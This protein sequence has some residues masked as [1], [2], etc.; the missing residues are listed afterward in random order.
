VS[1]R[2]GPRET[3]LRAAIELVRERGLRGRWTLSEVCQ[4]AG[5][6]RQTLYVHFRDREDLLAA[7]L[8]HVLDARAVALGAAT[9]QADLR[10]EI[11]KFLELFGPGPLDSEDWGMLEVLEVARSSERLKRE[12]REFIVD[13]RRR[14]TARVAMN[15]RD[16]VVDPALDPQAIGGILTAVIFSASLYLQLG[17]PMEPLR[18][19]SELQ[20]MLR[21]SLGPLDG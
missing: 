5:L 11:V 3:I 19:I 12:Y 7:C 15:Q 16:G 9:P 18:V 8:R 6:A 1:D 14:V 13:V 17:V 10:A 2:E 21:G 20:R 4:R